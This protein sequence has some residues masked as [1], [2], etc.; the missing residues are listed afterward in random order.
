MGGEG[1]MSGKGAGTEGRGAGVEEGAGGTTDVIFTLGWCVG[2]W[3]GAVLGGTEDHRIEGSSGADES[4]REEGCD[5]LLLVW[6]SGA[7]WPPNNSVSPSSVAGGGARGGA[8]EVSLDLGSEGVEV[9]MLGAGL[10]GVLAG[11]VG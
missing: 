4:L 5:L 3:G 8:W 9:V 1:L 2:G 10:D 7:P 11:G 6:G